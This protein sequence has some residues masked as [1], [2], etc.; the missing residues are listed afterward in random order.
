MDA[1]GRISGLGKKSEKDKLYIRVERII[2]RFPYEAEKNI[3]IVL[4]ANSARY[5]T[6]QIL[7]SSRLSYPCWIS[8]PRLK[9]NEIR[10]GEF[11]VAHGF[12]MNDRVILEVNHS[13]TPLEVKLFKQ[14][15]TSAVSRVVVFPEEIS[16]PGKVVEGAKKSIVVNTYERDQKARQK[17]IGHWGCHC[18]VCGADFSR[19]YGEL[20]RGFIHVHHLKPI[21]EIGEEY[22]LDPIN[23]LR[24][25]CPNCHAMI[26]RS[27]PVLTIDELHSIIERA[28]NG[29]ET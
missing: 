6:A 18:S 22:E 10:L 26:H 25:V 11:L 28:V 29:N 8:N 5:A 21:A 3:P 23:D 17:C 12:R 7:A 1:E 20:G 14:G 15:A 16:E 9:K 2:G 24:P 19:L 13:S 27:S 4:T